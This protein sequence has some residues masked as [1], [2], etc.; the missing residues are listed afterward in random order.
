MLVGITGS[1]GSGRKTVLTIL[2]KM[3]YTEVENNQKSFYEIVPEWREKFVVLIDTAPDSIKLRPWFVHIHI[4]A[5]EQVRKGRLNKNGTNASNSKDLANILE[6]NL[7]NIRNSHIN[8]VNN[9]STINELEECISKLDLEN[10]QRVRPSWDSY[11]MSIANLAA[12]RSNCMKRR[13][14]CVVVQD[15]K[16]VS[17]GYNGTPR[18]CT[19]CNE[20]GCPRC[21]T[22]SSGGTLLSTCYCL[23]A[24][25]NALL[26]AGRERVKDAVLYCNTCPCVTCTIK[27]AQCGISE[28]IY[29]MDYSMD[30]ETINIL[31]NAGISCRK[32][33]E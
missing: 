2:C 27:I 30:N 29:S 9:Y 3:G 22:G 19:N 10:T 15:R 8:L 1:E 4:E 14:G 13:V 24:E 33:V 6:T 32:F 23:H 31:Q 12:Q 18:G 16:I 21:N 5:T 28:V 7:D 20:G 11:F 26:E 25:E 17:T